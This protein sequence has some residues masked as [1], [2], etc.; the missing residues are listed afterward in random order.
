MK[1]LEDKFREV[2]RRVE[3]LVA[4]NA[5]LRKRVSGLERELDE[6]RRGSGELENLRGKKIHIREKIERVLNALEA[7]GEK[8]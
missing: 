8:K 7:V 4:E 3:A 5:D 6:A 1:D 2:E